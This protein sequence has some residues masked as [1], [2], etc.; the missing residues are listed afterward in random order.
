MLRKNV[1][2]HINK[3]DMSN[4]QQG[5]PQ[6][7]VWVWTLPDHYISMFPVCEALRQKQNKRIGVEKL[8]QWSSRGCSSHPARCWCCSSSVLSDRRLQ[9]QLCLSGTFILLRSSMV[10]WRTS[11]QHSCVSSCQVFQT[12]WHLLDELVFLTVKTSSIF[13][14]PHFLLLPE[15]SLLNLNDLP[16][17][18]C[19]RWFKPTEKLNL[20]RTK[21]DQ[22]IW[23]TEPHLAHLFYIK[24]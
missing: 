11:S 5:A 19:T 9:A 4:R 1:N 24:S 2:N 13:W 14:A 10:M 18:F 7:G 3:C 23:V 22:Q 12:L 20:R 17:F 8:H 15:A 16:L 6:D 21:K